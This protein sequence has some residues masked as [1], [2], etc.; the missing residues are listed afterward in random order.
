MRKTLPPSTKQN[1]TPNK[2]FITLNH[3]Y[4]MKI[5]LIKKKS[6]KK[7]TAPPQIINHQQQRNPIKSKTPELVPI[8]DAR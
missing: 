8:F 1:V 4:T 5:A 6:Q 2:T 3:P 7:K